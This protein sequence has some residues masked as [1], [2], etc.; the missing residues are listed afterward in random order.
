MF[1][2]AAQRVEQLIAIDFGRADDERRVRVLFPVACQDA[3]AL[4]AELF[5]ELLILGVGQG[6]ERAGVPGAASRFEEAANLFARDP[7][8][9]A[10]RRRSHQHVFIFERGERFESGRDRV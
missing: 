5:R 1:A 7:G 6:F 3:D 4:R 2:S 8:L 9:A 10:P